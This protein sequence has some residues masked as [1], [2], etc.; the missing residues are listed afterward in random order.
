[1]VIQTQPLTVEDFDEFVNQPENADRLFEFIGR[2]IVEVPSNPYSSYIASRFNRRLA[3][4]V[5]DNN[6]GY[7]TGEQGGYQVS[8]ERYAPDVAFISKERQPE[9]ARSGYNPNPPDLAVEVISP[10]DTRRNI[11]IK[12]SNYLAAGTVVI[13]VDP[14]ETEIS[15]HHPG[16]RVITLGQADTFDGGNILP[17]FKLAVKDILPSNKDSKA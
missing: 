16:Q 5:E 9:L 11:S 10:T 6:L 12:V 2:E 1:M 14:E 3:A 4:F 8:G 13:L 7:V 15:V 17:G